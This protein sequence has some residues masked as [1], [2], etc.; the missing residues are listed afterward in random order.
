MIT[1][2]GRQDNMAN[3][4]TVLGKLNIFTFDL[5]ILACIAVL[6]IIAAYVVY[7]TGPVL[8]K[9]SPFAQQLSDAR[10]GNEIRSHRPARLPTASTAKSLARSR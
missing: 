10:A 7:W 8:R 5:L 9:R 6:L 2:I 1:D 4:S 3:A